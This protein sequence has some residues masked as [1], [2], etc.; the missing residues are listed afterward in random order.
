MEFY[1]LERINKIPLIVNTVLLLFGIVIRILLTLNIEVDI[2][3][4]MFFVK[5]TWLLFLVLSINLV[6]G[7]I[8]KRMKI[9][10]Y[11]T[12][13]TSICGILFYYFSYEYFQPW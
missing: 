5:Y 13:V 3:I 4:E 2:S 1:K 7:I 11:L 8:I 12:I 9:L 6:L 10:K